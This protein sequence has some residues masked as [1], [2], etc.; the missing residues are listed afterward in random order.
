MARSLQPDVYTLLI[1][2]SRTPRW[3]LFQ[4]DTKVQ[5]SGINTERFV[6]LSYLVLFGCSYCSKYF[7][8]I[9]MC[10]VSEECDLAV[11]SAGFIWRQSSSSPCDPLHPVFR[12]QHYQFTQLPLACTA[13]LQSY[14]CYKQGAYATKQPTPPQA[15]STLSPR[16]HC[17]DC[18]PAACCAEANNCQAVVLVHSV[19]SQ[20]SCPD[21]VYR[22]LQLFY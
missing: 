3:N 2:I 11:H 22:L 20:P 15:P 18:P 16:P 14:I 12:Y 19:A 4:F 21:P 13:T 1:N 6:W 9:F 10:A 17:T 7:T 5:S 8:W